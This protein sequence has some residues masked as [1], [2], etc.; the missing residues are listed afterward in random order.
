MSGFGPPSV[1]KSTKFGH[2]NHSQLLGPSST[3]HHRV[4]NHWLELLLSTSS[5]ILNHD[6]LMEAEV[7]VALYS[8]LVFVSGRS[9]VVQSY[10]IC[11][12]V[13]SWCSQWPFKQIIFKVML[14][15][16]VVSVE[17][18]QTVWLCKEHLKGYIFGTFLSPVLVTL[19][20]DVTSLL[21]STLQ[22][23]SHYL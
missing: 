15:F 2:D 11:S 17:H 18:F 3:T 5:Q 23:K 10:T 9:S 20:R 13:C 4:L 6:V 22:E 14:L 8:T 16:F 19:E 21:W 1:D 7:G 12:H